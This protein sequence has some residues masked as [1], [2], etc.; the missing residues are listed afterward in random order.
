MWHSYF[1]EGDVSG[2]LRGGMLSEDH[3][4]TPP[5]IGKERNGDEP[6]CYPIVPFRFYP[7]PDFWGVIQSYERA[8]TPIPFPQT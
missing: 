5:Y 1:E 8:K 2:W 6:W 7:S 3:Y 4:T